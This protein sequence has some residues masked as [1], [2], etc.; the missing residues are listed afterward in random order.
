MQLCTINPQYNYT[1]AKHT[2]CVAPFDTFGRWQ[3]CPCCKLD[4]KHAFFCLTIYEYESV[5]YVPLQ[6]VTIVILRQCCAFSLQ[7][8]YV[9]MT[10]ET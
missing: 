5:V 4:V 3:D 7:E 2:C 6:R 10:E 9:S 1:A 8:Q